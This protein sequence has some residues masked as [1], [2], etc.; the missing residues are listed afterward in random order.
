MCYHAKQ[1]HT[2]D[3]LTEQGQVKEEV[4]DVDKRDVKTRSLEFQRRVESIT[5]YLV[6]RVIVTGTRIF[7]VLDVPTAHN[8]WYS[9]AM[10]ESST[11]TKSVILANVA[12]I[13]RCR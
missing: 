4:P 8:S 6:H 9:M 10:V 7:R 11:L 5:T 2:H 13:R 12:G 1:T 3:K